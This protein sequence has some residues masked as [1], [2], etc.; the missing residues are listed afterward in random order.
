[1]RREWRDGWKEREIEGIHGREGRE[2]YILDGREGRKGY[3][4]R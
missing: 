2:R 4:E 3:G 1:M